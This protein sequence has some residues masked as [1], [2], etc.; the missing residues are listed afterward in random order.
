MA[1]KPRSGN[2]ERRV[3]TKPAV[4]F[5]GDENYDPGEWEEVQIGLGDKID[6][7]LNETV[8]LRFTGFDTIEV[9]NDKGEKEDAKAVLFKDAEEHG[10][11]AWATYGLADA[12]RK[13]DPGTLVR[14]TYTGESNVPGSKNR[15]RNYVVQA[16]R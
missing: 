1:T 5:P 13:I 7:P 10:L 2:S 15:V 12:L 6:F 4:G 8:M 14:I 16:K 3:I 9:T 11:F